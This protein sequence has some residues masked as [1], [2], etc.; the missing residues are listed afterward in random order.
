MDTR[1]PFPLNHFRTLFHA[2]TGGSM[3]SYKV[4]SKSL[5]H[6]SPHPACPDQR[7]A[8]PRV[9]ILL[10]PL[11][12]PTVKCQL[13]TR[14]SSLE[15]AVP[16]PCS[17]LFILKDLSRELSPLEC[18]VT[19][20]ALLTPLECAV[21]KKWGEWGEGHTLTAGQYK[22][23]YPS[24]C[25]SRTLASNS[26]DKFSSVKIA[27][28]GPSAR[29]RPSRNSTTRSISG[30]ISGTWCVTSR[31]PKPDCASSRI[32]SR[33]CNCAPMSNALLGS[34]KSSAC[35]SCT[36]ARAISVRLASPEDICATGRSAR[37][38]IPNRS[39]AASAFAKCIGSGC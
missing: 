9:G 29:I 27:A 16:S 32:V 36:S 7:G 35:G 30:M 26:F 28:L 8:Q 18:A 21:T 10:S 13:L 24:C 3:V 39:S 5:Y 34:S 38:A 12:L 20:I 15:C 37:C 23:K 17:W 22:W 11:R 31:M 19:K 4:A 14:L 6:C 2:M 33:N 1:N 25:P